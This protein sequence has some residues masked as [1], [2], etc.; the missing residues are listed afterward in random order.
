VI[1]TPSSDDFTLKFTFRENEFFTNTELTKTFHFKAPAQP[2]HDH[3]HHHH[4]HAE[5]EED[6]PIKTV[7]TEIQWKEGKNIT[8]KVVQKV[9]VFY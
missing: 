7:G 9:V 3:D 6:F 4:G 1:Y 5:E 8:K 2:G